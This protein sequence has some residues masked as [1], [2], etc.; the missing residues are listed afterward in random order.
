[1]TFSIITVT[2]NS[3]KHLEETMSSVLGQDFDDFEYILID[4]ESTDTTLDII[5]R[6]AGKDDRVRWVSEPDEGISDAFNK[7][8]AMAHGDI[9]GIINSDDTY[10][11]GALTAVAAAF[12]AQPACDVVHGDMLRFQGH[13]PLFRLKATP[14][15]GRIWHDMP[16][17]HPATFVRRRAYERIGLFDKQ[18]RVAMDYDLVLRLFLAGCR[19]HYLDRIL[20]NMRY[21]GAS[22]ERFLAARQE[23][24]AVTVAAGYPRWRAAGWFV[25]KLGMNLAKNMLRRLGL[26]RLILLHPKFKHHQDGD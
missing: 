14:V 2:C 16:L 22:D 3:G 13:T 26:N 1:V 25:V 6:H 10:A 7:G 5:K 12:A 4:G 21:G 15:D 18:L 17:N 8:I 23:V 19:F 24:Y 20:A 9:I 11:A